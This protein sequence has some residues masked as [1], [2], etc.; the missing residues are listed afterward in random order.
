M[1]ESALSRA[2]DWDTAA[3]AFIHA[4]ESELGIQFERGELSEEE[5]KRA[6][7]LVREKYGNPSWMERVRQVTK[8]DMSHPRH[9]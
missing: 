7:E 1:L 3:S 2:V 8:P 9:D 6:E 4:F 5:M